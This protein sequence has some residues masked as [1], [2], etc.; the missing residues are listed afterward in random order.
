MYCCFEKDCGEKSVK[1]RFEFFRGNLE[2]V[3]VRT[4]HGGLDEVIFIYLFDLFRSTGYRI[5]R[6]PF[7]IVACT[8]VLISNNLSRNSFMYFL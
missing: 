6:L 2:H 3:T 7:D 8:V 4:K 1:P 5:P